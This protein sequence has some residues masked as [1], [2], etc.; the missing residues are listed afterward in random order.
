MQVRIFTIPV[1]G[2]E[3]L[4]VEMNVFLR[5]KRV[6]QVKDQF[7]GNS[8]DTACWCFSIRYVDDVEAAERERVRV[9]YKE[10]LDEAS[11]KRFSTM[12]IIRKQ[13]AQEAS[14]PP[15]A[16]FTDQELAELA[17]A[18]MRPSIGQKYSVKNTLGT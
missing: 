1:Q 2:G 16:V 14:V 9:D 18:P 13:V 17:K 7:V 10:I 5:S 15:Y 6:L 3:L 8:P 4:T 12:R 11:F